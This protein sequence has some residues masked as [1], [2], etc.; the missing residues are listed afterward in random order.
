MSLFK[1]ETKKLFN[2]KIISVIAV[3][4]VLSWPVIWSG[5]GKYLEQERLCDQEFLNLEQKK[6]DKTIQ[7]LENGMIGSFIFRFR[8]KPSPLYAIFYNSAAFDSL[9]SIVE[10]KGVVLDNNSPIGIENLHSKDDSGGKVDLS[11]YII[12]ALAFPVFLLG[13]L[14]S[15]RPERTNFPVNFFRKMTLFLQTLLARYIYVLVVLFAQMCILFVLFL[16]NGIELSR[17][18]VFLVLLY[19]GLSALV[20]LLILL[21][22]MTAGTFKNKFVGAF[23]VISVSAFLIFIM[24][25]WVED[26]F[27]KVYAPDSST[28]KHELQ[29][30]NKFINFQTRAVQKMRNAKDNERQQLFNDLNKEYLDNAAE[31][32]DIEKEMLA[33]IEYVI[34]KIHLNKIFIPTSFYSSFCSE[35]SSLGF[36]AY[37]DMYKTADMKQKKLVMYYI[38]SLIDKSALNKFS[39]V[40]ENKGFVVRA[41][42]KPPGHS[43]KGLLILLFYIVVF[44]FVLYYRF[45]KVLLPGKKHRADVELNTKNGRYLF[46]EL[47]D[48]RFLDNLLNMIRPGKK[49]PGKILIDGK[50]IS[51]KKVFYLPDL[52]DTKAGDLT[53]LS[54]GKIVDKPFSEL[55][56]TDIKTV[57]PQVKDCDVLILDNINKHKIKPDD[58]IILIEF[59]PFVMVRPND[60]FYSIGLDTASGCYKVKSERKNK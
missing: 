21:I 42:S 29:K 7:L 1:Y 46:V 43:G 20:M 5:I 8:V 35:M 50:P 3:F 12:F 37:F 40:F 14:F 23:V 18:E 26:I 41:E 60:Y 9:H 6:F 57:F 53:L 34:D 45:N 54:G 48:R 28:Y 22:A 4:M 58:G 31:L 19:F 11:T 38:Q 52:S 2:R 49:S 15:F 16:C 25:G 36:C 51:E 17:A 59:H 27:S 30:F 32:N 39:R 10:N 55:S 44:L 56:L 47:L 33:K 24:Q 13:F